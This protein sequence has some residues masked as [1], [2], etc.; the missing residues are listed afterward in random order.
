MELNDAFADQ[1]RFSVAVEGEIF[2]IYQTGGGYANKGDNLVHYD[3]QL[4]DE[5]VQDSDG[6]GAL[7]SAPAAVRLGSSIDVV[8][9]GMDGNIC[10]WD[11]TYWK[12]FP[13][14][15]LASAPAIC[16]E[17]VSNGY[18]THVFARAMN[19][20]LAHSWR[21]VKDGQWTAWTG[22][23]NGSESIPILPGGMKSAPA[24]ASPP[25]GG[26]LDIVAQGQDNKIYQTSYSRSTGTWA[27]QW[28]DLGGVSTSAPTLFWWGSKTLHVFTRG[29]DNR[30]W[31]KYFQWQ[32]DGYGNWHNP[33]NYDDHVGWGDDAGSP[34]AGT[35]SAPVAI[36]IKPNLVDLFAVG[37]NTAVWH[38]RWYDGSWQ[39]WTPIYIKNKFYPG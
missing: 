14:G 4:G 6:G 18:L 5:S 29:A 7:S 12:Q 20:Q 19:D 30:I 25:E 39:K 8:G 2:T 35:L 21:D 11:G 17:K 3:W 28:W 22:S 37:T 36:A 16:R 24:V 38:S 26:R 34:P 15:S 33:Y 31:H 32:D 1:A 27:S 13:S 9:R 10:N 23:W